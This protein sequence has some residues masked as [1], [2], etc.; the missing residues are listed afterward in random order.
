MKNRC[1]IS[2]NSRC[3]IGIK[4]ENFFFSVIKLGLFFFL[5]DRLISE[6]MNFVKEGGFFCGVLIKDSG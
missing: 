2:K 4:L 5:Y 3:F 1:L 6:G